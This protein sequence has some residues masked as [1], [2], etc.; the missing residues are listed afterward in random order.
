MPDTFSTEAK[1]ELKKLMDSYPDRMSAVM[2]ALHL[3]QREFGYISY[4]ALEA[5]S[6]EMDLPVQQL[7]DTASFYTMYFKEPVGENVIWVCH[8]L[9]CALRGS[10]NVFEYLKDK[11]EIDAGETTNDNRFTLMKAECLASCGSAPM[12]QVNDDYFEDLT[13]EKIDKIL[14]K[15]Y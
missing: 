10:A 13:E 12:M 2:N 8:T 15:F 4:E 9:P 7:E 5:L 11:L 6:K 1:A 3:T 14:G